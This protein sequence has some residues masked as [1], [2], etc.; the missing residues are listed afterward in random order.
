MLSA[1]VTAQQS[2]ANKSAPAKDAPGK[3][4][5][6]VDQEANRILRERRAQARSLLLSLAGD[7]R[8]FRDQAVRARSLARI[9]DTLWS[10]DNEQGRVLFRKAWEAAE[11]ADLDNDKKLQEEIRQLQTRTGGGYAINTPPKLLPEVL[12]LAARRDRALGEEFLDKLKAQQQE[13]ANAPA[14]TKRSPFNLSEATS[15]RLRLAEELLE[16]GN[17]DQAVQFADPVLGVVSVGTINFLSRLREKN[18]GAAD[19]RYGAMLANA[20]SNMQSDANTVS[21]LSSYIFTPHLFLLFHGDGG[22]SSSQKSGAVLPA[23]VAPELR[24]AFLQ[25]AAGILLRPQPPPEQDQS[26][27]GIAGKYLVIKRLLPLFEQFA[28]GEMTAAVR[29]Q[30]ETM[31]TLVSGDTR[32]RDDEW[33][34]KG[35]RPERGVGEQEQSIRDRIDHAKTSAERD[36]LYFELAFM[37]LRKG[38]LRARDFVDKIEDPEFRKQ[39]RPYVDASLAMRAVEQK[40]IESALQLAQIG[41][42]THVQRAW[43]L[44][45]SAQLLAATDG[46]KSL[47]LIEDAGSEARRIE[48]S[49]PDRPRALLAVANALL[50]ID[51][52]R[53]WDATFEAVKAANSAEGFTGEDGELNLQI[54]TRGHSSVSGRGVPDFDLAGIFG[55]LAD[56]DYDRAVNLARGFQS[57][58]PRASAVIA[59][60]GAV[61][62]EKKK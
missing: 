19:T 61:F 57:E 20:A 39:A 16:S 11:V 23:N 13:A 45:E 58:A 56:E 22:I 18:A 47:A 29:A 60:A 15:Q 27:S 35:L 54:Q 26:S 2:E 59:I 51:R 34:Q 12:R 37:T 49:D 53:V 46:Q 62:K 9:A 36:G 3:G 25:T 5:T 30:F 31:N 43:V 8:S 1:A 14:N 4:K 21:L 38:D 41:D 17:V 10:V 52:P 40:Q 32:Q 7:A 42:L 33:L 55:T 50:I 6:A 44:A 24:A 28:P 48:G